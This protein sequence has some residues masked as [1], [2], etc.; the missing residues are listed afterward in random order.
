ME[1]ADYHLAQ[2]NI[3]RMVAPIGDPRL[4]D[5]VEQLDAVNQLAEQSPGFIW[6]LQTGDGNATDIRVAPD[7]YI[8]ANMSVWSFN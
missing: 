2:I 5:F 3:A 1:K 6:R 8:L 4:A 7:P